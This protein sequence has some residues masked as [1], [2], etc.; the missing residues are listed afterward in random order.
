M[1]DFQTFNSRHRRLA[2]LRFLEA[3]PGYTSNV[4][5]LTDVLNSDDIGIQ[6]SR[7]QTTTELAWLA[8]NG[9]VTL[10]GREDFRVATATGRGVEIALGRAT[11]PEIKRPGPRA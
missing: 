7:D 1:T 5:I 11:H 2:I 9:F 8:E 4:S 6:T 10:G 3:S